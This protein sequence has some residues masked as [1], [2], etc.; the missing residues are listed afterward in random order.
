MVLQLYVDMAAPSAMYDMRTVNSD[1]DS[2][3]E[4]PGFG[5]AF[6]GYYLPY[7]DTH[8]EGLVTTI[9]DSSRALNWI[10]VDKDTYEVK[11][12]LRVD[13]Q[14]N[15]TGPFDCTRQDRRMTLEGWEGFAVVEEEPG[16]WALYFD[17]DDDGLNSK[18]TKGTRVLEVELWRKEK[19]WTKDPAVR[20]EEQACQNSA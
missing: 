10:Y 20:Q 17:R 6:A 4:P 18:V 15:I 2:D 1:G 12:G 8:F 9:S 11:Y 13:A 3:E 16:V 14:P 19:R 7:P 5:H